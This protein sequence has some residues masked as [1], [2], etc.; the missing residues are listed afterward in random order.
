[1]GVVYLI[2]AQN[3][4]EWVWYILFWVGVGQSGCGISYF[5]S[6]WVRVGVVCDLFGSKWVE[7][8][9]SGLKWVRVGQSGSEWVRVARSGV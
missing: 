1:M 2:L 9:Q 5:G 3:G 6:E 7:V 4:S 8:G